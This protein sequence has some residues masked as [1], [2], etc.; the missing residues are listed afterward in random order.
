MRRSVI[1]ITRY[2]CIESFKRAI[3]LLCVKRR[4]RVI[5][6]QSHWR[7][8]VLRCLYDLPGRVHVCARSRLSCVHNSRDRKHRDFSGLAVGDFAVLKN[9]RSFVSPRSANSV[10]ES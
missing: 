10:H 7:F 8:T 5:V 6:C 2:Y 9:D 3:I 4:F 1:V